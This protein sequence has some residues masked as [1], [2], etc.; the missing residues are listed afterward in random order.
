MKKE[1]SPHRARETQETSPDGP[2]EL[3]KAS[4]T[5][6]LTQADSSEHRLDSKEDR[7]IHPGSAK[8]ES[9]QTQTVKRGNL[10]LIRKTG[11]VNP[12]QHRP[13]RAGSRSEKNPGSQFK[14]FVCQRFQCDNRC[15]RNHEREHCVGFYYLHHKCNLN[16]N[17]HEK[18]SCKR[19]EKHC[20]SLRQCKLCMAAFCE[21][22]CMK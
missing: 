9:F 17:C 4:S 11:K 20:D 21:V 8:R 22:C 14:H 18:Y 6:K 15:H 5:T 1:P 16:H 2:N 7:S 10:P 12:S 19:C 13:E 3:E